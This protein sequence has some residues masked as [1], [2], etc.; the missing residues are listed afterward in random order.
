MRESGKRDSGKYLKFQIHSQKGSRGLL[1]QGPSLADYIDLVGG[2]LSLPL[3]CSDVSSVELNSGHCHRFGSA[4]RLE[5]RA[6]TRAMV[7]AKRG[8]EQVP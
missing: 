8:S 6:M 5:D 3:L 7:N 1:P 2:V 4:K